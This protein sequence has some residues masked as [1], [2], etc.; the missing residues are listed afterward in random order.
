[1]HS[2][3]RLTPENLTALQRLCGSQDRNL[4]LLEMHF[5]VSIHRHG[6]HMRVM[7]ASDNAKDSAA[8][9]AA[10]L[11]EL[12]ALA[13]HGEL[14]MSDAD[15][16][17][18]KLSKISKRPHTART[19]TPPNSAASDG[20]H[21]T[22]PDTITAGR[23]T[24]TSKTANQS[25]L[26]AAIRNNPIT[27]AAGPAGTGK[28]L[29]SVALAVEALLAGEAER[30]I[31]SRP[32]LEAGERLGFLPGGVMQKIDPFLK[33]LYDILFEALGSKQTQAWI[34]NNTIELVPLAYMRGRTFN[35]AFVLLDEAQN[36]TAVQIKM[37]LTRIGQN[38]KMVLMGDGS[39]CDLPHQT[40]SG[41]GHATRILA[42]IEG[43]ALC[44]LTQD[45]VMRNPLI[46]AI[47]R[48]YG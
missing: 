23:L 47:L 34:D 25:A 13:L 35:N 38:A 2:E 30:I 15:I 27:F 44:T 11:S 26:V 3:V 43:I 41:F 40:P 39:Q 45:D 5:G 24:L 1:M 28:T 19:N 4:S 29:L 22:I 36:A 18:P 8:N 42:G 21:D 37:L 17:A 10:R 31:L 14:D 9:A 12:Y 6:F 32:V 7:G 20:I 16:V 48:A 46:K 33:P